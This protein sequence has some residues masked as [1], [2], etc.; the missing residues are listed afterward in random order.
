[1]PGT[2][3]TW[4]EIEL[5]DYKA[6]SFTSDVEAIA[7][8]VR[9]SLEPSVTIEDYVWMREH[10]VAPPDEPRPDPLLV[11]RLVAFAAEVG[12]DARS[13]AELAE[14]LQRDALTLFHDSCGAEADPD[15]WA[16]C[17]RTVRDWHQAEVSGRAA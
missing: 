8:T 12:E 1:M 6:G 5:A 13:L 4:K 2:L 3:P 17:R 7:S 14:Q 15:G 11:L 16:R 9:A 10:G